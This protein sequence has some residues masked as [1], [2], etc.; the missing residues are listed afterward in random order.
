M[1]R[2]EPIAWHTWAPMSRLPNTES[3]DVEPSWA[4]WRQSTYPL[5]FRRHQGEALD[6]L[7]QAFS[8]GSRRAW[9]VLPPGAGKTVVGL[10]A[11]RRLGHPIVV[12]GPNTAIQ[13]QWVSTWGEFTPNVAPAGTDRSLVAPVTA[14]TYQSLATFDPDSEVDEDGRP[15]AA[16]RGRRRGTLMDRL[17]DNGHALVDRLVELG[18][19][20]LV[21]DECHHLLEVWGR[22]LAE[23]LEH[24][25]DAYVVGLTGTPPESLSSA[26][27]AL[28][29]ELFGAPL[30]TTSIPAVVR[31][32]HLAPF[33]ELAWFTEPTTVESQWLASQSERFLRLQT[34]LLEPGIADVGLLEWLDERIVQ[35]RVLVGGDGGATMAWAEVER[36]EPAL[37][38][39]AL[40]F[41]HVGLLGLPA[42]AVTREEHRQPPTA[43]DWVTVLDDWITERLLRSDDPR[44]VEL[45]ERI[46][47]ALPGVGF[48]LT[49]NGVRRGRSPVHRVLARS[50]AKTAAAVEIVAAESQVLGERL[51]GVVLCDHEHA[52]ATLPAGLDGVL[53]AD[54]GSARLMLEDLVADPRT[55]DRHPVLVTGRTVAC[56]VDT[57]RDLVAA[58][59]SWAP[60]VR[61]DPIPPD[62][63][64]VVEVTGSWQSRTW[65]GLVTRYLTEG[66]TEMLVGTRGLLGEGWDAACV[67]VLI[68]L[69]TA[70]TPTAVVQTRGRALRI[71]PSW[72]AKV[73]GIWTVVCIAEDHPGGRSDWERFVRKHSGYLGVAD[74]G[75]IVSGVSHVDPRLSP[76]A[77]PPATEFTA[78]N[79]LMLVRADN[80]DRVR[81]LWGIGTAYRD[82]VV[83][84][85]RVRPERADAPSAATATEPATTL[86]PPRLVPTARGAAPVSPASAKERRADIRAIRWAGPLAAV[87]VAAL[88]VVVVVA[89]LTQMWPVVAMAAGA[90]VIGVVLRRQADQHI[91][92]RGRELAAASRPVTIEPMARAVAEALHEAGLIS[93]GASGVRVIVDSD[94]TYR[95]S[96]AGID[97]ESSAVFT[98]ALDEVVSPPVSPRYLMPR[99]LLDPI[100]ESDA[101]AVRH[102][103]T[104][105]LRGAAPPNAVVHH[106]V[107]TVLATRRRL[108]R[109]AAAWN[110]WVSDGQPVSTASVEGSAL[111][112]THRDRSPLDVVTALR[113][114][115]H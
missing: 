71:D 25:P 83:H 111:L 1:C 56:A 21:L 101:D 109:F 33:A 35:R 49:R 74:T 31:E 84:T 114:T 34:D 75:E 28:V 72:A 61:L 47:R 22:L 62:A 6:A 19:V 27:A 113:E 103:V 57:A 97:R 24:L 23:V 7:E 81:D 64:G 52:S 17:H 44:D 26:E 38:A 13:A 29:D 89:V 40:R 100:D 106:A 20:T 32:G 4:S 94:G 59:S 90:M 95:V 58:V 50:A 79:A 39:A 30:H 91:A 43:D 11:A 45:I 10:E 60:D 16:R 5:P 92:Q 14:L 3:V 70:T 86:E 18:P 36:C 12:F 63:T 82:E 55:R 88:A 96:L 93:V 48:H 2:P 76:Y 77:P 53:D 9:V 112:L 37:A 73:A 85:I 46:R 102:S 54:A 65:V 67:N 105:W 42:G 110:R 98:R 51:R 104:A 69:T 41:H 68:D 108:G 99:F 15:A 80:R 66:T 8:S 107:P 115:W 87:A 78:E